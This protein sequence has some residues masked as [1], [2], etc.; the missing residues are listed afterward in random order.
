MKNISKINSHYSLY[1]KVL[2]V[3][4]IIISLILTQIFVVL[5][6]GSE[7]L[8]QKIESQGVPLTTFYV[9][10]LKG[11]NLPSNFIEYAKEDSV[12]ERFNIKEIK[13]SEAFATLNMAEGMYIVKSIDSTYKDVRGK[14]I[15]DLSEG[16][17]AVSSY[18]AYTN[19]GSIKKAIGKTIKI[20]IDYRVT[21]NAD[22]PL[23]AKQV[24]KKDEMEFKIV[25]VYNHSGLEKR[26]LNYLSNTDDLVDSGNITYTDQSFVS[27]ETFENIVSTYEEDR[28]DSYNLL[29]R[30]QVV[31]NE[32]DKENE[33][34]L[35]GYLRLRVKNYDTSFIKAECTYDL[36]RNSQNINN[37]MKFIN[38]FQFISLN[39][40]MF[41]A[42]TYLIYLQN[43]YT[44]PFFDTL[45]KIG[46]KK[47]KQKLAELLHEG[48]ICLLGIVAWFIGN[49]LIKI[50]FGYKVIYLQDLYQFNLTI[51]KYCF[52][53]AIILYLFTMLLHIVFKYIANKPKVIKIRTNEAGKVITRKFYVKRFLNIYFNKYL[54]LMLITCIC[55]SGFFS[56][57]HMVNA[58]VDIYQSANVLK[59]DVSARMTGEVFT[60][61]HEDIK[62]YAIVRAESNNFFIHKYDNNE[63]A[64]IY[65]GTVVWLY[66]DAKKFLDSPKIGD[67]PDFTNNPT[68]KDFIEKY[69]YYLTLG[70]RF[71]EHYE[72]NKHN[73]FE[74]RI[75]IT[76]SI[77]DKLH[78]EVG[79]F[80]ESFVVGGFQNTAIYPVAGITNIFSNN[81]DTIY[82]F[83]GPSKSAVF[84]SAIKNRKYANGFF[85]VIINLKHREAKEEFIS[86]LEEF[87]AEEKVYDI[88]VNNNDSIKKSIGALNTRINRFI[89]TITF[90]LYGVL[91]I[92][93]YTCKK[94]DDILSQS[95][96]IKAYYNIGLD[97]KDIMDSMN[98]LN[99]STLILGTALG[100]IISIIFKSRFTDIIYDLMQVIK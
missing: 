48:Y 92:A 42:L 69:P 81:G 89:M 1:I 87:G 94:E 97:S 47:S 30:Y 78:S 38:I 99:I 10:N 2:K 17:I 82:I 53:V 23:L 88:K 26:Y 72:L 55:W 39:M 66:G 59:Y 84:T 86:K 36:I 15:E 50:I 49:I 19:F 16:E 8:F 27:D 75:W 13:E 73:P 54:I 83:P 32:Y 90:I 37:T 79:S 46:Y 85:D 22:N 80:I 12:I 63:T 3:S 98:I 44:K 100:F 9:K 20:P 68:L 57:N 76:K 65:K 70:E 58:L 6:Y 64:A 25:A 67:Y 5:F 56:T 62:D 60:S 91:L 96:N 7:M 4:I 71:N 43:R 45:Y 21:E 14:K 33:Y 29:S 31:F 95:K 52:I 28:E 61:I 74:F 11:Y 41:S 34:N 40:L 35:D 24:Y 77:A 51:I 18:Y 93:L